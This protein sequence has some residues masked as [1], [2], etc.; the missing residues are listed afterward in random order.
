MD[1]ARE[2]TLCQ[3]CD[4]AFPI[5]AYAH[6]FGLETYV[7]QGL[8][9]DEATAAAFVEAQVAWPLSY[10][11]L[12]GMR[13]AYEAAMASD[14]ACIAG[15]EARLAAARAPREAREA[16][17]RMA[18][19]FCKTA[20]GFLA[21]D[22][23]AAERFAAYA[24]AGPHVLACAY[25]VFGA[26]AGIDLE[27]LLTRY[28]YTQVQAMVVN[29]VKLVPLSQTAGQRLLFATQGAQAAAVARV[30]AT[31]EELLALA[32]PGFDVRQ[33]EHETLYSRLYMS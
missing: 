25:G 32:A 5:G 16:S 13:L 1:A 22:A 20:A 18:A 19:R 33:I 3:I 28:L 27:T 6:S 11:E 2:L 26:T 4:S 24:A 9:H 23:P 7:Q 30:L 17:A 31:S 29:C 14:L 15:L 21:A 10:T 12:L 8:V